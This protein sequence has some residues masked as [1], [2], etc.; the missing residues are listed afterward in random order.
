MCKRTGKIG[1]FLIWIQS[2]FN[3][4]CEW[5]VSNNDFEE[6]CLLCCHGN[7]LYCKVLALNLFNLCQN[8]F[9][10]VFKLSAFVMRVKRAC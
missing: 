7:T 8:V 9:N 6:F 2:H 3:T 4:E 1:A 5:G 10:V